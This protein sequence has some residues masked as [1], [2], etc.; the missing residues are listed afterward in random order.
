[1]RNPGRPILAVC[2]L[3]LAGGFL[4]GCA[5]GKPQSLPTETPRSTPTPVF[6]SDAQAL[7]AATEVY[8]KYVRASD[9][10]GHD[11]GADPERVR[12]YVNAA[13]LQHEIESAQ[14]IADENARGYGYTKV[15]NTVLQSHEESHG[16]ATVRM[17]ACQD[18]TGVDLRDAA[19]TSLIAPDRA[20][21]ISYVAELRTNSHGQLVIQSNRYWSGGGICKH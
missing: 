2:A 6:T 18:L 5:S 16:I 15:N 20:D 21:F 7:A 4:A 11:G 3:L 9:N 17:Y 8:K 19:G 13:G 1:M 10:I 14:R 12:P